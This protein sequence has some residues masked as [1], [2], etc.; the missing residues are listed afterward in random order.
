PAARKAAILPC[1]AGAC[2]AQSSSGKVRV[3]FPGRDVSDFDSALELW[4]A[5]L[6]RKLNA[7]LP[8]ERETPARLHE[9]IRYSVLN[10]GKRI[11]PVLVYAAGQMLGVP[12]I[13]LDVPA[14]AVELVHCYSLV[15]DDLPAM[16]DDDLRRGR[17]TTHRRFDEATAIL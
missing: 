14:V 3:F 17:P 8:S 1:T 12:L 9:A 16:D 2:S 13:Q 4:R 7:A 15:H 11:R 5:R 10:G 6:E